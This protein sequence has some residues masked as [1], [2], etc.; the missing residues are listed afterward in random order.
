MSNNRT[1]IITGIVVWVVIC[2]MVT[3]ALYALRS[4]GVHSNAAAQPG[5]YDADGKRNP[6]IALV[7]DEGRIVRL[8]GSTPQ[9][10]EPAT[11]VKSGAAP[12][13]VVEGVAVD[14]KGES[15]AVVN[16]QITKEGDV[17]DGYTVV[18]IG[19]DK[20]VFKKDGN[21]VDVIV[22]KEEGT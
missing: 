7:S 9:A 15:F 22:H 5:P 8:S 4:W 3:A 12:A 13:P 11:V 20:V 16:D 18:R 6:F 19:Y 14:P 1:G 2:F 17:V 10:E 21:F